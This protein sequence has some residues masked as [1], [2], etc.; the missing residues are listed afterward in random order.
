MKIGK[1]K[2]KWVNSG[3]LIYKISFEEQLVISS[4][5][6]K[7]WPFRK[8]NNC[9]IS[10]KRNWNCD[11]ENFRFGFKEGDFIH[12]DDKGLIANEKFKYI[13][14]LEWFLF[15]GSMHIIKPD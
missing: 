10:D 9:V 11:Y 6:N 13:S 3:I 2:C 14:K 12:I 4:N 1:P 5:S 15:G 7:P 8:I